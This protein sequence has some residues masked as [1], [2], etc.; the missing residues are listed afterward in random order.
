[1]RAWND[2][3]LDLNTATHRYKADRQTV[4]QTYR[5]TEVTEQ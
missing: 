4:T 2:L 5:Q 3:A 1:M